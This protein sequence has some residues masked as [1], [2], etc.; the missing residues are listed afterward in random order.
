MNDERKKL[1]RK[2]S[3]INQIV[4]LSET[5]LKII[6]MIL[7][8]A[9]GLSKSLERFS[10]SIASNKYVALII[11]ISLAG[12]AVFLIFLPAGYYFNF[13]LEHRF[14]LSNQTFGQWLKENLKSNA[15][16]ALL[17]VPLL[18]IFYWFISNSD[19]WWIYTA[20][21][22]SIYSVIL[23]QL[24]PVLIFPLFYKFTALE[25]GEIK[26]RILELCRKA[27][28]RVNGVYSFNMSKTTKKANAAFTGIGK[29]KRIILA[30]TL[31]ENFTPEEIET[32][33]AH[34]LGHYKKKHIMKNILISLISIF[35]FLYLAS[36]IYKLGLPIFGFTSPSEIAALP[37]LGVIITVLFLLFSPLS[38]SISRKFEF[39]A[40]NYALVMTGNLNAFISTFRKLADQNLADEEPNKI[41]EFWFHS[42]P[43]I[44]KRIE[45]AQ[46]FQKI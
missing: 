15:V 10:F 45:A 25:D 14:G 40:D 32:V 38:S 42:H 27:D 37:L 18:L 26:S 3:K 11:F 17:T 9:T 5:A 46:L 44:K 19:N 43:S 22:I 24:A 33:F 31:I 7:F 21:I 16:V 28:F 29:T 12:M 41:Y 39:E 6:L 4:T 35:L 1:A 20:L 2:Y 30:D 23:A 36:E 34:E 13:R 8:I